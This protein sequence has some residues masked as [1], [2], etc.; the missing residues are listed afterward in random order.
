VIVAAAQPAPTVAAHVEAVHAAQARVVVFPELSLTGYELDAPPVDPAGPELS[1]LVEACAQ[2]GTV[3]FAGAPVGG[4]IAMLQVSA[5]GVEVAYRKCHL[6][7][8]EVGRFTPGDGPRAVEIDGWRVGLGLCKDTGTAEHVEATAAL[9]IDLYLAGLV[10]L[11]EELAEQDARG[12]RIA[13]TAG[14]Y[15]ALAS[16]AGPTGFGYDRTAGCSAIWAPDGT[17]IARTGVQPGEIARAQ[18]PV[19]DTVAR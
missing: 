1:P 13:R 9:G 6:G 11:P 12:E 7:G 15:V 18:L 8:D 2:T 17:Q 5:D 19:A 4:A 16:F 14:A 10:H 3:A